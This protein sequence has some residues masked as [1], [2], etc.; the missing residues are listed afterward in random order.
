MATKFQWDNSNLPKQ[1]GKWGNGHSLGEKI[2]IMFT[3]FIQRVFLWV[4]DFFS[5]RLVD[6]FDQSMKIMSPGTERATKDIF[7]YLESIP[8]MPDFF[9]SA[10]QSAKTEKGESGFILRA[11]VFFV[12]VRSIIF[13]GLEPAQRWA[14]YNADKSFRSWL[15]DPNSLSTMHRLGLMSDAGYTDAMQKLGVHDKLIPVYEELSRNIPSMGEIIAGRWREKI[16]DADF[17]SVLK[18]MGYNDK[19]I[20]L[21]KELS[22]N[23]PPLQDLIRM[24]VR[25]AFNDSASNQYGYDEDFPQEINKFFAQQGYNP[26][27]AKRYWRSHWNLPSPQQGYEMLHRGLISTGD[28]ET[29][30]RISDYPKFWRE[31]LRD[32]SFNVYT[33]VDVRRLLQAGM[34][35]EAEA[36]KAYKEQGYDDEKARKLTD[37]ALAGI[38]TDE[39]D[40]TKSD[41]LNLYEEGL[42]DRDSTAGNLVKMG[43]DAQE[44]D[45]ILKLSDIAI[46]KAMRTDLINYTKE[47]FLAKRIDEGGARSELSQ[48]GLKSQSVDRYIFNWQRA[49][50]I[51]SAIPSIADVK[52]WYAG[53]YIDESKFREYLTLHRH[54]QENI[55]LYVQEINDKKA[56]AV[57]EQA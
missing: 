4:I 42:T 7:S 30:L 5:D 25:D 56:Q 23:L 46:A 24:L 54:T 19:D 16:N 13:G 52:R 8:D 28:L 47:K 43:Y 31:K 49:T 39:K 21:Y 36:F 17:V 26:D 11:T 45:E 9:K 34:L 48:I 20:E 40:L 38:T 33:R 29:L 57:N 10:L 1:D 18:R 6:I 51:E 14:N 53:D 55:D 50:E 32:I 12:A 3:R 27:W 2:E 35:S 44:A 15:P 22:N 41:V 37:F